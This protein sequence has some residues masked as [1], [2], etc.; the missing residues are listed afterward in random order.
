MHFV[1]MP[2]IVMEEYVVFGKVLLIDSSGNQ[3]FD[4]H[5]IEDNPKGIGGHPEFEIAEFI[6]YVFRKTRPK[7][8][9]LGSIA[10]G[11]LMWRYR[12][13]GGEIHHIN[14]K[15]NY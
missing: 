11:K 3:H 14:N 4:S 12:N 9:Y 1:A 6:T 2:Q 8:N 5:R 15:Y 7:G 10:Y 13:F